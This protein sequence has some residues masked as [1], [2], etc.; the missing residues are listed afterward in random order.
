MAG[1][2]LVEVRRL[3]VIQSHGLVHRPGSMV[4]MS[5][6]WLIPPL[7]LTGVDDALSYPGQ[8]ALFYQEFPV[9]LRSTDTSMMALLLGISFYL[10]TAI[11]H[12]LRRIT[13]WLTEDWTMYFGFWRS[14]GA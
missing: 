12:L 7:M 4:P 5:G 13:G 10:S 3:Q 6:L 14:L 2:A 11:L 9:S 1:S 8:V